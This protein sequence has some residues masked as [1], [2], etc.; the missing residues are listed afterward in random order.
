MN[1]IKKILIF[2][3]TLSLFLGLLWRGGVFDKGYEETQF[4]LDTVCTISVE[5][6]KDRQAVSEAFKRINEIHNLMNMYDED[7]D[8]G[9]I[10]SA[11]ANEWIEVDE[12]TYYVLERALEICDATK[13]NFDITIGQLSAIWDFKGGVGKV[14]EMSVLD[15]KC[16]TVGYENIVLEDGKVK[17][18]RD[19]TWIDLGG[20]AKGY[21]GDEAKRILLEK[22]VK[23]G[24]IDLGGNVIAFG[25][26]DYTI[27]LQTPFAP[28]GSYE[29]TVKIRNKSVVTSGT[30]Q[31]YFEENK[32]FFHHILSP[33][34]G[35]PV[36]REYDSV[37]VICDESILGDCLSTAIFVMG[38]EEGKAL[39]ERYGCEVIFQ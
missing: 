27:G 22:G 26:R 8:V 28:A 16:K 32:K 17:K 2:V 19:D 3:L 24:L 12:S 37:T 35:Y 33:K 13:G 6:V 23:S 30:Y 29:K 5:K 31:R 9:R 10:N 34:N 21:A 18:L 39:G 7:S 4:C 20:A 25:N 38:K 36:D 15:E 14:P 11:K 1:K